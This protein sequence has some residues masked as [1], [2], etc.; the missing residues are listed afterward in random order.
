AVTGVPGNN[1]TFYFGSVDGGVWKTGDAGRTWKPIFDHEPV[2]SIGALAVAPSDTNVIYVGTG[3]G[4]MRSD[5]A[6]GDGVYKSTNGGRTWT[7][8]GLAD[9]R[10]IARII[11]DPHDPNIVF[12]AALGHPYGPNAERGVF[13]SLDGG[14]HWQKVLYLNDNTGA[15]DLAFKPGDSPDDAMRRCGRRAGRLERV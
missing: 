13:R 7:H 11:V 3:E 5:V 4:D 14:R 10:Q 6:Q 1:R 2:G 12:V 8:L 15:V 9:T